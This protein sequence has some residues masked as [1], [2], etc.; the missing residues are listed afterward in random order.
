MNILLTGGLGYIGSHTAVVLQ[1]AGHRVVLLDNLS[2]SRLDVADRLAAILGERP[3]VEVADI[4]DTERLRLI[5]RHNAID[6]VIHLA[7]LKA[8]GESVAQPLAYFHNNVV[9]TV[10]LLR[11]MAD[12]GV[13]RLVFSSSATVYG[14]PRR[15]PLDETHP[16]GVTS[17]NS[18]AGTTVVSAKPHRYG[19]V[20]LLRISSWRAASSWNT[21]RTM[22]R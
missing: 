8:V 19:E 5:L 3:P 18:T 1:Q 7:G 20:R 2:N 17:Q 10:S 22:R 6:A 16:T 21:P 9:G 14:Q 13:R 4:L 12:Q 15:L 11:A